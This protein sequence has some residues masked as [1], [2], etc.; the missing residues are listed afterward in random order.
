MRADQTAKECLEGKLARS[1]ERGPV[2][3]FRP[4]RDIGQAQTLGRESGRRIGVDQTQLDLRVD[5]GT[6]PEMAQSAVLIHGFS[7]RGFL[8][9]LAIDFDATMLVAVMA[10]VPRRRIRFVRAIGTDRRPDGLQRQHQN[11]EN[12]D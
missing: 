7:G 4:R 12:Q 2:G 6:M 3:S 1:G 9:R 8:I 10:E 5:E 11:E